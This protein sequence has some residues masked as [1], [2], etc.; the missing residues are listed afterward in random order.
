MKLLISYQTHPRLAFRNQEKIN[1]DFLIKRFDCFFPTEDK[2]FVAT[3]KVETIKTIAPEDIVIKISL[4]NP[5]I[6][7]KLVKKMINAA[8]RYPYK[9]ISQGE[10]P[11][12]GPE[13]VTV[14]KNS[15]HPSKIVYTDTQRNYNCQLNLYRLKRVKL[16]NA[17]LKHSPDFHTWELSRLLD[18]CGSREGVRFILSYGEPQRLKDY[19]R[20]PLCGT[21][22]ALPVRTDNGQPTMG[23]LTKQSEYYFLCEN[24]ELIYRN[25]YMP[26]AEMW[27][28]YD[29]YSLEL[30]LNPES[31]SQILNHLND[32]NT[33]ALSNYQAVASYLEKLEKGANI[34]D[35]GGGIGAFGVFAKSLRPDLKA[36]MVDYRLDE[37]LVADLAK[38]R[39]IAKSHNFLDQDLGDRKF[40]MVTTWEVIEHIELVFLKPFFKNVY[41]ALKPGGY[42]IFSTPDFYDPYAQ[43]LDFWAAQPDEHPSVLSRKVLDPILKDCGFTI[44]QELRES[45]TIKTPDRWFKYGQEN[46]ATFPARAESLI[47]NNFQKDEAALARHKIF[48]KTNNLGSELILILQK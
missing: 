18:Y 31:P 20:C 36:L 2:E 5:I 48:M 11:G 40:D 14:Q 44:I 8:K 21:K 23:F 17:F 16:F 46:S 42:Y 25:P 10:V 13:F 45:V 4:F 28:Y 34:L 26:Q 39:I 7:E 47:I 9:I 30:S 12:T 6:D 35:L 3:S 24:C 1:L 38:G 15:E 43:A 19:E 37:N 32:E 27:R 41:R 22:D 33:S 29:E